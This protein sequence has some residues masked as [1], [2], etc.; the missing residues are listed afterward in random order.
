MPI[1][2][3]MPIYYNSIVRKREKPHRRKESERSNKRE[4][5]QM[6]FILKPLTAEEIKKNAERKTAFDWA[7]ECPELAD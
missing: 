7:R 6:L 5:V 2:I 4:V 3:Y 1:D